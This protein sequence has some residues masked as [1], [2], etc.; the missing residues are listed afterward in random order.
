MERSKDCKKYKTIS[1]C[2]FIIVLL[3]IYLA[4]VIGMCVKMSYF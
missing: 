4:V 3:F 1:T 2:E